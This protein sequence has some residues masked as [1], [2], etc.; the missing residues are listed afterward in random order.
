MISAPTSTLSTNGYIAELCSSELT[1]EQRAKSAKVKAENKKVDIRYGKEKFLNVVQM[2][3]GGM[4]HRKIAQL[5]NEPPS[6]I[7]C[8]LKKQNTPMRKGKPFCLEKDKDKIIE[9]YKNGVSAAILCEKIQLLQ[10]NN[11]RFIKAKWD[12]AQQ[13]Q[14][15]TKSFVYL[16]L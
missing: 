16:Y 4:S 6:T 12:N 11:S 2:Y 15:K 14:N 7:Y 1:L 8:Y 10:N 5:L 13:K 3:Q 9:E